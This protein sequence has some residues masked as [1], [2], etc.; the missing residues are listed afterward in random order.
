[1]SEIITITRCEKVSPGIENQDRAWFHFIGAWNGHLI[2]KICL[3]VNSD[4]P[5]VEVGEEYIILLLPL[6]VSG[7]TLYG[8]IKK[9]SPLASFEYLE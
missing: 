5:M 8:R 1:M 9:I 4:I 6:R 7:P 3:E 2:R